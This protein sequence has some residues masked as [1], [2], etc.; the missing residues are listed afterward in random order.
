MLYRKNKWSQWQVIAE[1]ESIQNDQNPRWITRI[2]V[3]FEFHTPQE[4]RF[5]VK[6]ENLSGPD[7]LIGYVETTLAEIIIMKKVTLSRSLHLPGKSTNLGSLTIAVDFLK[8]SNNDV[9]K[10]EL[11][12]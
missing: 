12:A 5:E 9:V 3:D 8:E 1:T 11:A 7:D 10:M 2:N 6:K 4:L